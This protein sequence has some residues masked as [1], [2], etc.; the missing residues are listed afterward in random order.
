MRTLLPWGLPLTAA[1][2]VPPLDCGLTFMQRNRLPERNPFSHGCNVFS[3]QG[4]FPAAAG[5]RPGT[6][7]V[8]KYRI[9]NG[10]VSLQGLCRLWTA[11][12]HSSCSTIAAGPAA[13]LERT[14][15]LKPATGSSATAASG[16]SRRCPWRQAEPRRPRAADA[17]GAPWQRQ[18]LGFRVFRGTK[19]TKQRCELPVAQQ[20]CR[21]QC[22]S[23]A[24]F[25]A[26]VARR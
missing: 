22:K 21:L 2:H 3:H 6:D 25:D 17:A 26:A 24:L 18:G 13:C 7:P 15:P 1:D 19:G 16:H 5:R 20:Q 12:W 14:M 23:A 4:G 10:F 8:V 9:V 11:P